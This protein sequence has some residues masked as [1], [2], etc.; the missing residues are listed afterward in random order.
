[1]DMKQ[2][3]ISFPVMRMSDEEIAE[4]DRQ[5]A[6][7]EDYLRQAFQESVRVWV[8]RQRAQYGD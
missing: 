1:M 3:R 5:R 2:P 8:E 7:G 4:D 6:S